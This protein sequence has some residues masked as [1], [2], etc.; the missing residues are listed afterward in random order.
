L[1]IVAS[2]AAIYSSLRVAMST[3]RDQTI[4]MVALRSIADYKV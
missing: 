2:Y 1:R 3:T 4:H